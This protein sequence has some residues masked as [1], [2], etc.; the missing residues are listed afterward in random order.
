[1]REATPGEVAALGVAAPTVVTVVAVAVEALTAA[2]WAATLIPGEAV[3]GTA[4]LA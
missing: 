1:M 4:V 3:V 2:V